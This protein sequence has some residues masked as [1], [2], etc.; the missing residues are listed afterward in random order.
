MHFAPAFLNYWLF[1]GFRQSL[2]LFVK[3][4][5]ARRSVAAE[6]NRYFDIPFVIK[7]QLK[8]LKFLSERFKMTIFFEMKKS[9]FI[10]SVFVKAYHETQFILARQYLL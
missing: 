3:T 7:V 8:K 5:V 10:L 4:K 2:F 1:E 9:F 6:V